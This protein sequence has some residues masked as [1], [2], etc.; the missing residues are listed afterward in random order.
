VAAVVDGVVILAAAGHLLHLVV[1]AAE[2]EW[3]TPGVEEAAG[4]GDARRAVYVGDAGRSGAGRRGEELPKEAGQR[5]PLGGDD[6][7]HGWNARMDHLLPLAYF[8][9][10]RFLWC[11]TDAV[12]RG[13]KWGLHGELS[14]QRG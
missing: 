5:G 2:P 14:W 6:G 8:A 12:N 9:P 13:G 1:V 11:S 3:R 7:S 4:A 10:K